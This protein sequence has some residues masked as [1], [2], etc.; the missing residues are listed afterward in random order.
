MAMMASGTGNVYDDDHTVLDDD[1]LNDGRETCRY[2]VR[3]VLIW[4]QTLNQMSQQSS[5][6]EHP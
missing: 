5:Q 3:I 2:E 4:R 1:F 6:I